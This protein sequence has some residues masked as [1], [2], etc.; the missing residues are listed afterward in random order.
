LAAKVIFVSLEV[1]VICG[2]LYVFSKVL[3]K[4]ENLLCFP[5]LYSET[6]QQNQISLV[7]HRIIQLNKIV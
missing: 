4:T 2:M 5:K 1:L 7:L 3:Q 6:Y